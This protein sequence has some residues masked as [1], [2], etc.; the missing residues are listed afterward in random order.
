[1]FRRHTS[2]ISRKTWVASDSYPS[3]DIA[4]NCLSLHSKSHT[5]PF[6][7]KKYWYESNRWWLLFVWNRR[8]E[9][10]GLKI[11]NCK[12]I[13]RLITD[14][15]IDLAPA[16]WSAGPVFD[17][18]T[19]G[20]CHIRQTSIL[21]P[22]LFFVMGYHPSQWSRGSQCVKCLMHLMQTWKTASTIPVI[23]RRDLMVY[24]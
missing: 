9:K 11:V 24:G 12:F 5:V 16:G 8:E 2:F 22:R 14:I 13:G 6:C 19:R 17:L 3:P 15:L 18:I 10:V 4:E 20:Y 1:M 21:I 23:G 7:W